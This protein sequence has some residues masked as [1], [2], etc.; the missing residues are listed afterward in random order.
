MIPTV[1][2][3]FNSVLITY[4]GLQKILINL[5]LYHDATDITKTHRII[6]K[7]KGSGTTLLLISRYIVLDL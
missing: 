2:T 1:I 4:E 5:Q 6:K 3:V 7:K